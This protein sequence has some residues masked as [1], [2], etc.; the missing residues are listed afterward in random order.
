MLPAPC[1]FNMDGEDQAFYVDHT[2]DLHHAYETPGKPWTAETLSSGWEPNTVLGFKQNSAGTYQ[3]WG[4]AAG[5]GAM[6][7][8]FWNGSE[9]AT[10]AIG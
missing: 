10:E 6:L 3:V 7:Q 1:T 2:G 4:M 9:W 5:G 8:C